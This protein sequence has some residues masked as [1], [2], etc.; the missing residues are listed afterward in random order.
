MTN[1]FLVEE[2]NRIANFD[3]E[4][5]EFI[6]PQ[7]PGFGRTAGVETRFSGSWSM[8][9]AYTW[10][11]TVGQTEED[12]YLEP[13]NTHDLAADRGDNGPDYRHQFTSAITYTLPFGPGQQFFNGKARCSRFVGGWQLN[14]LVALYSG[15]A[16]TPQLSYDPTN[17]GSGTLHPPVKPR[18][19][20]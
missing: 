12:E 5:G 2:H 6:S 3:F 15:Q 8:L 4:T 19:V 9:N 13:P 16:F 10:Q 20:R 11:H 7:T 18:I 1:S 17:T 14:S